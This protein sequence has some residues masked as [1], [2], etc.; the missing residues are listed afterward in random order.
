M[1]WDL[2]Y[3]WEHGLSFITIHNYVA[4]AGMWTRKVSKQTE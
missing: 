2:V 4:Y 1:G 3:M